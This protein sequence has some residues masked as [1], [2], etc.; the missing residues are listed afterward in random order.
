MCVEIA[1]SYQKNFI[2]FEWHP[3]EDHCVARWWRDIRSR[4]RYFTR[5]DS[6]C[7]DFHRRQ[8]DDES[9]GMKQEWA[10]LANHSEYKVAV[11]KI[12]SSSQHPADNSSC[13]LIGI[14]YITCSTIV[15][16][17]LMCLSL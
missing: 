6:T 16:V 1:G 5:F 15:C 10:V 7:V 2:H 11:I 3:S 8:G 13:N 14:L 4:G 17:N 12:Q 9:D